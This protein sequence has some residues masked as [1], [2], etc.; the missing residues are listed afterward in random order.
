VVISDVVSPA[1]KRRQSLR[2]GASVTPAIGAS[3]K[4]L[5]SS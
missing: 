5:D 1:P 3:T 4:G 2:N